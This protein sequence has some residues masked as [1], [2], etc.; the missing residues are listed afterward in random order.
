VTIYVSFKN[1]QNYYLM[2]FL[3][4]ERSYGISYQ[5]LLLIL[6]SYVQKFCSL[7][8]SYMEEVNRQ[9]VER[10]LLEKSCKKNPKY[11]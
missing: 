6:V 1:E 7:S 11:T 4:P 5:D 2:Q 10:A 9:R 8:K 3:I